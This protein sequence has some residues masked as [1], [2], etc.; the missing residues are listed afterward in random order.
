MDDDDGFETAAATKAVLDYLELV[1]YRLMTALVTMN[2]LPYVRFADSD[3]ASIVATS[4]NKHFNIYQRN[5]PEF[6]PFGRS[7]TRGEDD[8]SF[9]RRSTNY[10]EPPEPATLIIVD[11]ADDIAPALMHDVT[12][13][14]CFVRSIYIAII[15]AFFSFIISSLPFLA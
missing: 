8:I 13:S 1:A 10:G 12:Y 11:R 4:L 3:A 14:V 15:Y 5:H 2:E 6:R 9:G 7:S